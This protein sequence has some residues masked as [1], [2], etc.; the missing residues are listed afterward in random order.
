MPLLRGL[1][2]MALTAAVVVVALLVAVKLTD[3]VLRR[4]GIDWRELRAYRE[5]RRLYQEHLKQLESQ[6]PPLE[7]E[8]P[9]FEQAAR[10]LQAFQATEPQPPRW[11]FWLR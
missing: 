10:T 8:S 9:E 3:L 6:L 1:F 4:F 2:Y 11:A 5:R 7:V